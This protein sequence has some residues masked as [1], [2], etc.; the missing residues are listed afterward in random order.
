MR[1]VYINKRKTEKGTLMEILYLPRFDIVVC[2]FIAN[3][4][5]FGSGAQG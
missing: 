5:A 2:D 1:W 4:L 3:V